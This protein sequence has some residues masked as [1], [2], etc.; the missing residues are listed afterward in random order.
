MAGPDQ[1]CCFVG[2]HESLRFFNHAIPASHGHVFY[3]VC[4]KLR[5]I[6]KLAIGKTPSSV[7]DILGTA[8]FFLVFFCTFHGF[9]LKSNYTIVKYGKRN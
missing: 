9:S 8:S 6:A 5:T 7:V 1:A 2:E 4:E 3:F